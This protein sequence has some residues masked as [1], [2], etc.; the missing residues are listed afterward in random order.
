MN[1]ATGYIGSSV[2]TSAQQ[3][4]QVQ[5]T[6]RY[7]PASRQHPGKMLPA[8]AAQAI[9]TYTRPGDLVI[10]PMCGIGTTLVEAAHLGRDAIGVEYEPEW[11]ALA[12]ANIVHAASQGAAGHATVA[13]GDARI[14]LPLL[15]EQ[16]QLRGRRAT[17]VLTSPPYGPSVHGQVHATGSRPVAKSHNRYSRDPANLAHQTHASLIDGFTDILTGC[18][19]LLGPGGVVAVTARPYRRGGLLVDIPGEV[20]RAGENAGLVLHER[21]VCLLARVD[22]PCLIPRASFFQ[23]QTVREARRHGNPLAV[24]AHEDLVV[25]GTPESS[26]GSRKLGGSDPKPEGASGFLDVE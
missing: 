20:I 4:A 18:R 17:L 6:G 7:L 19:R 24:I 21:L 9:A 8:I 13:G 15:K 1:S 23:L 10:D 11:S 12:R 26:I 25:F 22:G 3:T 16:L 5:R 14:M 2:W